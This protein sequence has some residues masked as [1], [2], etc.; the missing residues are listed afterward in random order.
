MKK[1]IT[2]YFITLI[3][4]SSLFC[5]CGEKSDISGYGMFR[6]NLQHTGIYPSAE[7]NV[8]PSLLWRFKTNGY[9]NSS[10]AIK[11]EQIFFGSSDGYLYCL[12]SHSGSLIWKFKTDGAINSSPAITDDEVFFGSH[13]GNFYALNARNGKL[14][15]IFKTG[16]EKLFPPKDVWHKLELSDSR[17]PDRWD[18]WLSSPAI[19][20][21]TVY[22]GSGDGNFYA[23][24]KTT[25]KEKWKYETHSIIHSSPALAF[26][27]VYFGGWDTY[28]HVLD[29]ETGE[30]KWKFKTGEDTVGYNQTGITSS[31]VIVDSI[32]YFGCRDSH[33]YA[34]NALSGDFIWK[35]YNDDIW[36]S[37][38]PLVYEEKVLYPAGRPNKFIALNKLTGDSIYMHKTKTGT[39]S[40]F[41]LAGKTVYYGDLNGILNAHDINTGN[42]IW[43]YQIPTSAEDTLHMINEDFT[44]SQEGFAA[45][46][47]KYQG[48]RGRNELRFA[49]GAIHSSPVI[50]DR[51][52]Y[53]GSYDG[54]FY[55]LK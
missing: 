20:K 21:N 54:Y 34:L 9:I 52:V 28:L 14:K 6:G 26:G 44:T 47:E 5:S 31:P 39:S 15:W 19:Q 27:N 30:E 3:L 17:D 32:L 48:V 4:T 51:V 8:N 18:T 42:L 46:L 53:F 55:A 1:F 40:S 36:V 13:D 35:R 33:I 10:A 23:L 41:S 37:S 22:F 25:G 49:L 43:T 16:G 29:E 45:A 50:K 7:V 11:G 38:T 24:D 2:N 12:N